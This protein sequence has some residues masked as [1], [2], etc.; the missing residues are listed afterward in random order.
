MRNLASTLLFFAT[1][2]LTAC[3]DP[4]PFDVTITN[5]GAV[6]SYLEAGEGSG[7]LVRLEQEIVGAWRP[8]A[9]SLAFMCMERCGVPG[10]IVCA[11]VAAELLV[12]HALL[13]GDSV[14][15]EFDGE[16]WYETDA[17]CAQRA[18]LNGPMRATL[19]HDD[20][21]VD[22]NGDPVAEPSSSG[23]VGDAGD[24]VMLAEAAAEEF[25]FDLSG[26]SAVVFKIA[27]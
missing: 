21:I 24:E 8:L 22:M 27:P 10:Q 17:R 18:N 16:W 3:I 20:E 2:N 4:Q 7:V 15:K 23:P 9:S 12:A 26:N 6:T 19:R 5:S 14:V 11:D 25:E 13:P 1:L